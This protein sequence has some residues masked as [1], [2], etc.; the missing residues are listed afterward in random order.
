A[1]PAGRVLIGPAVR[2]AQEQVLDD[3]RVD[4]AGRHDGV[5]SIRQDEGIDP[6]IQRIG[7]G[8]RH[9]VA[10]YGDQHVAV[11]P[12]QADLRGERVHGDTQLAQVDPVLA[13]GKIGDPVLAAEHE[14]V[15]AGAAGQDVVA[16]P[17]LHHVV[18]G[19]AAQHDVAR[20]AFDRL[21]APPPAAQVLPR[22]AVEPDGS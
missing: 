18:A 11:E 22:S 21:I 2:S 5:R 7:I 17:A 15:V 12:A 3:R 6:D 20:P 14:D 4:Y 10:R 13:D 19:A 16:Q 9:T 8:D 1:A